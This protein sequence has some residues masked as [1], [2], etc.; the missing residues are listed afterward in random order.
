MSLQGKITLHF[1]FIKRPCSYPAY[2][3]LSLVILVV[4]TRLFSISLPAAVFEFLTDF[5]EHLNL[6]VV[7]FNECYSLQANS[8]EFDNGFSTVF[9]HIVDYI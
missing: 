7:F 5:I 4:K 1:L 2:A 9:S 6:T 3:E 8:L